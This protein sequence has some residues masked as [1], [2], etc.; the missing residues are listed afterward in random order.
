MSRKIVMKSPAE[1]RPHPKNRELYGLPKDNS[2][3]E[4]IRFQMKR[5]GFDERHPLLITTEGCIISGVTRWAAAKSVGLDKV[6][7][8]V[9]VPEAEDPAAAD[10]EIRAKIIK[11]NIG[12]IRTRLQVAREQM[13]MAEIEKEAGR[14]RMAQGS[15]GG[16]SASQDRIAKI[17][18]TSGKTVQRNIKV[19]KAI[20]RAT[21][22]GDYRTAERLTELLNQGKT[23]KACDLIDGKAAGKA[24]KAVKVE[25]PRTFNDHNNRMYSEGFEASCK[26]QVAAELDQLQANLDRVQQEIDKARARLAQQQQTADVR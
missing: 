16:P 19:A 25:V 20:D 14:A 17:F 24:K 8:E 26:A 1:L 10:R 11:E 5:G 9:F 23:G 3:Y 22:Q 4:D 21:T 2:A 18:T 15:D 12:R 7:C 6:P 13:E